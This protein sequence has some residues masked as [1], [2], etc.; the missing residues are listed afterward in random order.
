ML[1]RRALVLLALAGCLPRSRRSG[2]DEGSPRPAL[3]P[4][5]REAPP[6][7][8][9]E[10]TSIPK[11][12]YRGR[13]EAVPPTAANLESRAAILRERYAIHGFSARVQRPFVL[14][15][16]EGPEALEGYGRRIVR[17]AVERLERA[18]FDTPPLD[19]IEV[20]LFA[21]GSSY[22]RNAR[23]I[24]HDEVDTPYGYFS[25]RHR[26]LVMNIA[27][28][29]GT[30]VHEIVHPYIE[31]NFPRCPSWFN[32]GL[33][34]LY[35]QCIDR[36]GHIWGATNWRL[37]GLQEAIGEG[38]LPSFEALM[39][40]SRD[41]FYEQD[42]GTNYAQAR[43]LC[44]WLQEHDKLGR[45]YRDFVAN[46]GEDPAGLSMLRRQVGEDLEAFQRDWEAW[47]MTLR[48]G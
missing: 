35:E 38:R 22:E 28:G 42:R 18:Y 20:W 33:A 44:Y 6:P 15:G 7:T 34:S 46:A 39:S 12:P 26:A 14:V 17:W 29:G 2:G 43:Y 45:F 13:F 36:D 40:T 25:P 41:E 27:T 11:L 24:F 32:E 47:V 21:D 30:L 3:P 37:S 4:P 23:V 5:E 19:I 9:T 31:S 8:P 16:D 48:Y 10:P 1:P